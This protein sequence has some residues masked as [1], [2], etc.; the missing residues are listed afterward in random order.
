MV[1]VDASGYILDGNGQ[2]A[3]SDFSDYQFQL[4]QEFLQQM[5]NYSTFRST[6]GVPS[7]DR[8]IVTLSTSTYEFKNVR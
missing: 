5:V 8:H 6:T 1:I 7:A 3:Y 4:T 2:V